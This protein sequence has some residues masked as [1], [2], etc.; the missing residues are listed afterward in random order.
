MQDRGP[1]QEPARGREPVQESAPWRRPDRRRRWEASRSGHLRPLDVLHAVGDALRHVAVEVAEGVGD[2]L[3]GVADAFQALLQ[4][5]ALAIP[6][7]GE[8][9]HL[10]GEAAVAGEPGDVVTEPVGVRER[11]DGG[12][13]R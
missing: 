10:A 3:Q 9:L 1:V 5:A 6:V 11:L 12:A 8:V 13:D 2:R 7:A 4:L